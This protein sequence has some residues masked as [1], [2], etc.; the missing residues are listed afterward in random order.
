MMLHCQLK[1]GPKC[2]TLPAFKAKLSLYNSDG[3]GLWRRVKVH[4]EWDGA[5]KDTVTVNLGQKLVCDI[6]L[7]DSTGGA[8]I[9][10]VP[11]VD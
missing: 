4:S 7:I 10:L 11:G 1:R 5:H 9:R 2:K 6:L 3:F 8:S